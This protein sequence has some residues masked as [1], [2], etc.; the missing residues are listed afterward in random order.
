MDPRAVVGAR[1]REPDPCADAGERRGSL[2]RRSSA[3]ADAEIRSDAGGGW[4]QDGKGAQLVLRRVGA[5]FEDDLNTRTL[6]GATTLDA[7]LRGR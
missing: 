7:S 5:Q 2:S 1:R 3:G 4:E 6:K